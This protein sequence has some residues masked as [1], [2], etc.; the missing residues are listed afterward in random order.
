M[1]T[2]KQHTIYMFTR[3]Y[4]HKYYVCTH[5]YPCSAYTHKHET[6]TETIKYQKLSTK[7]KLTNNQT[8]C[9]NHNG[10]FKAMLSKNSAATKGDR[11]DNQENGSGPNRTLRIRITKSKELNL[12]CLHFIDP[13]FKVL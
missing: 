11:F 7:S 8:R 3:F 9:M 10:L 6:S 2:C 1:V 13:T 4:T 5:A 12:M